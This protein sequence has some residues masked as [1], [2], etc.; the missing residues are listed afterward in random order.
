[1]TD[2]YWGHG[3]LGPHPIVW[4]SYLELND[5]TNTTYVSSYVARD[6]ETL[7]S[8]CNASALSVRS[9]GRAN[10]TGARYPPYAGNIPDGFQLDFDL[11]EK[12]SPPKYYM[13]WSGNLTGEVVEGEDTP[14]NLP[15]ATKQLGADRLVQDSNLRGVTIFEQFVILE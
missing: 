10:T 7:V 1:M 12:R 6:G 5:T 15:C 11:Y 4:F 3:T 8:S 9:I 13:R 2:W 14:S